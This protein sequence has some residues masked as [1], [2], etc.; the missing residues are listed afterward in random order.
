[1]LLPET[2]RFSFL[3]GVLA[4]VSACSIKTSEFPDEDYGPD[5]PVDVSHIPDAVPQHAPRSK[6]GNPGSYTVL[7]KTY[8]VLK[9][10]RNY[11][12]Q[13]LASWYG[14]KFHGRRTSSGEPYDM[15]A[16]TAAHKT[17]PLPTWVRVT[18]LDNR[19][20]VVVKVNDRGPFHP[21]RIIDLSYTAASKLGVLGK[22]TAR[23]E[24][25]S[26]TPEQNSADKPSS[27]RVV[28]KAVVYPLWIQV[29][30]FSS[31][32]NAVLEL[33]RLQTLSGY[34]G[35][36]QSADDRS[37]IMYRVWLGPMKSAME[38]KQ[39]IEKLP[40]WGINAH[41]LVEAGNQE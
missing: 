12:E 16:M 32:E 5:T 10:A 33:Q 20:S 11:R 22:G 14:N 9:D 8:Y 1:M 21:G 23:V 30:A 7:G 24:V 27:D 31:R 41:R 18:N 25:A 37:P 35:R 39:L 17:L 34:G 4:G 36:L 38:L 6:Y 13:G 26:L 2:I 15:Y 29:G 19:K 3:L 28:K 40:N